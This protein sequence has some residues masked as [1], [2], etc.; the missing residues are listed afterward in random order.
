MQIKVLVEDTKGHNK[1]LE[2][3]HGLSLY[4]K[5]KNH[6]I[7]YDTGKSDLFIK[8]AEK[9]GIDLTQI[10]TVIISHGHYDHGGGLASFLR[11]NKYAQI[12][13][14]E[15]A[16]GNYLNGE[17]NYI[18]LDKDLEN[19]D[20]IN[21]VG[22]SLKIDRE[23]YLFSANNYEKTFK[24]ECFGLK[25]VSGFEMLDDD[26]AHEQYLI[27]R[28]GKKRI[29]FSACSHKGI[30][31]ILGWAKPFKISAF[32]GGFHFMKVNMD[33]EGKEFLDKVA[34]ELEKYNCKFYTCHCTGIEQYKYLKNKLPYKLRY[35][36]TGSE[37]EI[38][39]EK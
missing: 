33:D 27:L 32:F 30:I 20:R 13:I 4:I 18:G 22:D 9:M 24:T 10:D 38:K 2:A 1:K 19:N 5:T 14:N 31:N 15:H 8:N 7:L 3:E 16:F 17:E 21:L 36:S 12:Y 11:V 25:K 34:S 23:L 29:L 39:D 37:I 35:I 28:E 26:F 6:K